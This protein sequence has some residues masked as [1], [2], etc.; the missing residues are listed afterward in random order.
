M[1]A[2]A[3]L[4]G[5]AIAL[6]F[7][8]PFRSKT[9]ILSQKLLSFSIIGLGAGMDL[10]VVLK[11]G[12]QG[13]A[14]TAV[15]ITLTLAA[16][17]IL[18]KSLK[19]NRKISVLLSVGTAICGGS[20]I[21][22][23]SPVIHADDEET[24]VA[25]ATIFLLNALG[26]VIFPLIGHR[27]HMEESVFGVWAALAIHDTS[28]VVGACL[29]Y[30][31]KALEYGTT[32]KLTRALW[33]VPL[34]LLL[35]RLFKSKEAVSVQTK[36]PWFILGFVIA[37]A[38]NSF[39]PSTRPVTSFYYNLSR[40]TFMVT[41]FLIGFGITR[42]ALKKVGTSPLIQA[43]LLWVFVSVASFLALTAGLINVRL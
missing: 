24:S 25:L 12:L 36:K 29:R 38:L 30:G 7:G 11:V 13:I 18:G 22:A 40:Y 1:A 16:G 9:K 17:L 10:S 4:S 23:A 42:E 20:A 19:N 3:L 15:G 39:I 8:N 31:A 37:A 43:V 14:Y 2:I 5:I 34:T 33:I 35:Q 26:L 21:A 6:I 32:V 27:L 28:S 41:L